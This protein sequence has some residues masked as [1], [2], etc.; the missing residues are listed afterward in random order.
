MAVAFAAQLL[1]T[2]A[3]AAKIYSA[4]ETCLADAKANAGGKAGLPPNFV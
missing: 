2:A 3:N 1:L 4:E